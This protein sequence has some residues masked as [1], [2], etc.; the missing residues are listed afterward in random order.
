M[1]HVAASEAKTHF[2]R[3]IAVVERGE[4]IVVTHRGRPWS[5]G[6]VSAGVAW[7]ENIGEEGYD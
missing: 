4:E 3:L 7:A 5:H 1:R 2:L 6:I